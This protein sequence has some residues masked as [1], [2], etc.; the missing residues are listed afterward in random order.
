MHGTD[1]EHSLMKEKVDVY[2]LFLPFLCSGIL[3][4]ALRILKRLL[5]VCFRDATSGLT[6]SSWH[7]VTLSQF[8]Q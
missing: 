2:M 5:R 6:I 8:A 3:D 7:D 1:L 4:L